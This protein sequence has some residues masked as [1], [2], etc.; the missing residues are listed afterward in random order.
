[1]TVGLLEAERVEFDVGLKR[2]LSSLADS[3]VHIHCEFN[4]LNFDHGSMSKLLEQHIL[5]PMLMVPRFTTFSRL[6]HADPTGPKPFRSKQWPWGVP[7]LSANRK[8]QV[9]RDNEALESCMRLLARCAARGPHAA[10]LLVAPENL[11]KCS[12]IGHA[13]I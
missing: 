7:G 3:G 1:M 6:F 12:F 13:S 8:E 9:R 10:T 11:G 4:H 5:G 2:A